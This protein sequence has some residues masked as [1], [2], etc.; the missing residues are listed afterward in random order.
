[1]RYLYAPIRKA[2]IQNS[3]KIK[4]G[5]G[6][7]AIGNFTHCCWECKN[8]TATFEFSLAVSYKTKHVCLL[9]FSQMSL[10]L[11]THTHKTCTQMFV[12]ALF[13]A[14][15]MQKQPGCPLGGK[16]NISCGPARIMEYFSAL[17][18]SELS[19][20]EKTLKKLKCSWAY[21]H[22][23]VKE[24]SL[25]RLHPVRFQLCDILEMAKLW[26]Q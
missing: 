17:Q 1:M 18:R 19:S 15:K 11:I 7:E 24:V 9:I 26:G 4:C 21:V 14:A 12:A 22:Y 6:C 20:H 16:W 5:W 13:I 10:N 25:K 3:D 2:K 8:G 23:R